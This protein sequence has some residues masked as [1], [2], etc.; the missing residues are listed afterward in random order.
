MATAPVSQMRETIR[1]LWYQD[2]IDEA[3]PF[4]FACAIDDFGIPVIGN[5]S[6]AKP[7]LIGITTKRKVRG[8]YRATAFLF[9]I[10]ATYQH[11]QSGYPMVVCDTFDANRLMHVTAGYL[12]SHLR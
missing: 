9:H 6:K 2:D 7:F 1:I 10:D 11:N 3:T 8:R 4:T 12:T 5:G